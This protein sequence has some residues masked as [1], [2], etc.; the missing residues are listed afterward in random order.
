M[1]D[2]PYRIAALAALLL[3]FCLALSLPARAADEELEPGLGDVAPG[4]TLPD[5]GDPEEGGPP[6]NGEDL[7]GPPPSSTPNN[8]DRSDILGNVPLGDPAVRAEM[9]KEL[10]TRLSGARSAKDAEPIAEAIEETWR[11]SG[12]DTVDLLMTRV[13]T[14]VLAA[15]L[16]LAMQV[17]D[18]VTELDP[19]NAEAWHQRGI[20]HLMQND[21]DRA[22]SDLR[23][24]ITID[25]NHYKALRD[26]GAVLQQTGD[27][28]GALDAYR[29]AL[30]VNPFLEQARRAEEQLSHDVEG[31]DI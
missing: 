15:D 29:K 28:R 27:Q 26:L 20:V 8:Q 11:R 13:D 18:A 1:I 2:R 6:P 19:K 4:N 22:L 7:T 21:T 30:A 24:A 14:F 3:S 25:P 9:L 12:S 10:Y 31:R 23:R 17:L 16:D 5:T